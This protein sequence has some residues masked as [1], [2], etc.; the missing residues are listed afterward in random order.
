M[1][2]VTTLVMALLIYT[3]VMPFVAWIVPKSAMGRASGYVSKVIPILGLKEL[4]KSIFKARE[5]KKNKQK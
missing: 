1:E 4:I 3:I 5:I 2:T